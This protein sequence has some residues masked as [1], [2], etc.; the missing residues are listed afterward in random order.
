MA[1][2]Q[3]LPDK[4]KLQFRI[5]V[6][7]GEVIEDRGDIYGNDV[8][9]AARLESL[10][11]PG[12]ICISETV[13]TTIGNKLSLGYEFMGERSVKNIENPVRAYQVRL[14]SENQDQQAAPEFYQFEMPQKPSIA[15]LPFTNMS[16]DPEQEF[17]SDGITIVDGLHK[18]GLPD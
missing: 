12:G 1:Q 9:I 6:N 5:D 13:R 15:V 11:D 8:N 2:N 18:A 7:L 14:H 4:D 3:D 17:F 16:G 10:A